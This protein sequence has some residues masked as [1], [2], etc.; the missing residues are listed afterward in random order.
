MSSFYVVHHTQGIAILKSLQYAR[1]TLLPLCCARC[2]LRPRVCFLCKSLRNLRFACGQS[3]VIGQNKLYFRGYVPDS[4]LH[5]SPRTLTWDAGCRLSS[6]YTLPLSL[7]FSCS[8]RLVD[9]SDRYFL[10][11]RVLFTPVTLSSGVV[12]RKTNTLFISNICYDTFNKSQ[13]TNWLTRPWF[14]R[15]CTS[16]VLGPSG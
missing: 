15:I 16:K 12:G 8:L 14:G 2:C 13:I 6:I 5:A 7:L 1:V 11:A 3:H 10:Y 9:F 4:A